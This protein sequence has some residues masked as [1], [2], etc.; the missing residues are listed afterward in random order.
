MGSCPF[1]GIGATALAC[2][3]TNRDFIGAEIDPKY[4]EIA[5]ERIKNEISNENYA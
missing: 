5:K 4:Y 3:N 1:A 2:Q